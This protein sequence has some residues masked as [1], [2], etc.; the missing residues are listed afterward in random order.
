MSEPGGNPPRNDAG[1]DG[2][3]RDVA[4]AVRSE[5]ERQRLLPQVEAR[6]AGHG[7]PSRIPARRYWLPTGLLAAI[8]VGVTAFLLLPRPLSFV[9]DGS[10]GTVGASLVAPETRPL[11]MR[12]SDGSQLTLPARAQARVDAVEPNGA[13]VEIESGAVEVAVVH[14]AETHWE[15]HAGAYRIKVTGTRFHAAW[16]PNLQELTVTMREGSVLVSG[17]GIAFPTRLTSGQRLRANADEGMA[18]NEVAA[19]APSPTAPPQA[20]LPPA[21]PAE[22]APSAEVVPAKPVR[23]TTPTPPISRRRRT[24]DAARPK[25]ALA[26]GG[27]AR[28]PAV[29]NWRALAARAQYREALAAAVEALGSNGWSAACARLDAEDLVLLGDVARLAGDLP[30][31]DEAYQAA[32]RRFPRAD[33]PTFALGLIAFEGRRDYRAAAGWFEAYLQRFPHGALAR[34]AAG[35][36]LESRLKSG[37]AAPARAAAAAY[38]RD[39]PNGPHA[40][41]ARRTVTP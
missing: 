23:E 40:A 19:P 22:L 8:G 32:R 38:L 37:D 5:A 29:G 3:M 25:L 30:R 14:R 27:E 10:S 20:I 2:L 41:L 12:F 24:S 4:R 16:N 39:F 26:H 11:A 28:V 21:E 17:P 7:A 15:I 6:L 33:R 9:A 36:L 1:L 13:T 18:V 34:E 31:A 35:R